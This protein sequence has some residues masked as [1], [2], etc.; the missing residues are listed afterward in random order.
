MVAIVRAFASL[1]LHVSFT[2]TQLSAHQGPGLNPESK[3]SFTQ[4]NPNLSAAVRIQSHPLSLEVAIPEA[5]SDH[6][7]ENWPESVLRESVINI[8]RK[9]QDI[10]EKA[11][12]IV[13]LLAIFGQPGDL[14]NAQGDKVLANKPDSGFIMNKY[15]A[16]MPKGPDAWTTVDSGFGSLNYHSRDPVPPHPVVVPASPPLYY[17]RRSRSPPDPLESYHTVPSSPQSYHTVPSS[18]PLYY[19]RRSRSPPNLLES[20]RTEIQNESLPTLLKLKDISDGKTTAES[21]ESVSLQRRL[22]GRYP[23]SGFGNRGQMEGQAFGPRGFSGGV[24]HREA[25]GKKTEDTKSTTEEEQTS[26]EDMAS[27]TTS[28]S[29][30]GKLTGLLLGDPS[31][32]LKARVIRFFGRF[33]DVKLGCSFYQSTHHGHTSSGGGHNNGIGVPPPRPIAGAKAKK[34]RPRQSD[35]SDGDGGESDDEGR[36]RN[37][38]RRGSKVEGILLKQKIACPYFKRY[39]AEFSTWRTCVGPGFDGMNRMK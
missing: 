2:L 18:P 39:P 20:Y 27:H 21:A 12:D 23:P 6:A 1:N 11:D 37:P 5:E 3:P 10:E 34:K 28:T 17:R 25:L 7:T 31:Q 13:A 4:G 14:L 30:S 38:G 29:T 36:G 24:N 26:G 22:G 32:E 16:N 33:I 9:Q 8:L 19:G 35:G 15:F